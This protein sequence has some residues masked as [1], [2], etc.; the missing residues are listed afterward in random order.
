[1][2]ETIFT[3]PGLHCAGCVRPLEEALRR[4]DGVRSAHVDQQSATVHV[5]Y[6]PDRVDESVLVQRLADLG[7]SSGSQA[8]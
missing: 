5:S 3:L 8:R 2:V 7:L 4:L 6:S 1:M